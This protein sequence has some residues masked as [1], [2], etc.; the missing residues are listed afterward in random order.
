M[1]YVKKD[2]CTGLA[3]AFGIEGA[4]RVERQ[5]IAYSYNGVILPALPEWDREAY[6]YIMMADMSKSGVHDA[7]YLY[8]LSSA[9][10]RITDPSNLLGYRYDGEISCYIS[11]YEKTAPHD[12]WSRPS[13]KF[14]YAFGVPF[15]SNF[16]V[17]N[18][19]G[20]VYLAASEPIPVYE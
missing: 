14:T 19:D 18:A 2:F 15:W 11:V 4:E 17:L 16:D 9:D 7:I 13:K 3:L 20:S 5:P 1:G 8:M 10:G 6:P 12:G